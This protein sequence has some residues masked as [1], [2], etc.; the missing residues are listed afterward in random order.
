MDWISVMLDGVKWRVLVRMEMNSWVLLHMV[1][2]SWV[3]QITGSYLSA[4]ELLASQERRCSPEFV[5]CVWLVGGL[6]I[7]VALDQ[8]CICML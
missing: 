7:Q 5:R 8:R 6:V 2:K 4:E 1:M 3:P